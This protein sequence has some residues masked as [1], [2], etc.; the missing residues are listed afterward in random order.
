MQKLRKP[1]ASYQVQ[2]KKFQ[3]SVTPLKASHVQ[4]TDSQAPLD[5]QSSNPLRNQQGMPWLTLREDEQDLLSTLQCS[6][7][8]QGVGPLSR[9]EWPACLLA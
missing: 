3:R 4:Q 5:D 7:F 1:H 9:S 2:R 8:K 6:Y